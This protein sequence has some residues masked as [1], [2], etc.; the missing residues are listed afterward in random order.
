MVAAIGSTLYVVGAFSPPRPA[1]TVSA[2]SSSARPDLSITASASLVST[3]LHQVLRSNEIAKNAT[4]TFAAPNLARVAA[5][6]DVSILGFSLTLNANVTFSVSAQNG[7]IVIKTESV[8]V[9]GLSLGQGAFDSTVERTRAETEDQLNRVVQ[10]ALR[11]TNLRISNIR[12]SE[13]DVTVEL[14]SP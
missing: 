8:D 13:S 9:A 6:T 1:A 4:V 7:R 5:T 14:V 12:M 10:N 3:Q 11:G 2:S